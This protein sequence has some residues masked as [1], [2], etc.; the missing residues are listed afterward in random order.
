M[1]MNENT[2]RSKKV[3]SP[4]GSPDRGG[5]L[6]KEIFLLFARDGGEGV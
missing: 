1:R 2:P 5:E 3:T 4:Y 6:T